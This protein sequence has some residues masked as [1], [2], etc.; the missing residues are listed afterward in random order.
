MPK[1]SIVLPTYNG[2]KYI[3]QSIQSIINQTFRDWELIIVNDCSDDKTAYIVKEFQDRDNRIH[4]ITNKENMKLPA[5]LNI[6]FS[7]ANGEYLTWTSDDNLYRD[8]AL[9]VLV[10]YLNKNKSCYMV[11]ALMNVIDDQGKIIYTN[12]KYDAE[13]MLYNNCVGACFLYRREV[14]TEIG[15]YNVNKFL[16]EDYDYW[17]RILFR[18]GKID[19]ID[20]EL[21][22]YRLH[23]GSLTGKK[24]KD[25]DIQRAKLRNE[26]MGKIA[27]GL[28]NNKRLLYRIYL[29]LVSEG[30]LSDYARQQ[31]IKIIPFVI[32]G[33]EIVSTFSKYKSILCEKYYCLKNSGNL[34][35]DMETK[36]K[37]I[38]PQ[39]CYETSIEPDE[40]FVIYGAGYYGK[41][42][43]IKYHDQI[44]YYLD[45]NE[46]IIGTRINGI[47]V[48][49]LEEAENLKDKIMIAANEEKLYDMIISLEEHGVKT[50]CV[51]R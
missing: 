22:L 11:C 8:N 37:S 29:E 16:V 15:Q 7:I 6:G 48:L 28:K 42:A 9:A 24:K 5:S 12:I 27:E 18:Y 36:I 49:P 4:V 23:D 34:T 30:L 31:I 46:K 38:I 13:V 25:I 19:Y 47:K 3:R 1:I 21:Y 20:T 33:T 17:L 2:E 26:Y 50:Y 43:Y 45:S 41:N 14:L 51:Y 32:T 40:K 10:D 35:N 39:L 44:K